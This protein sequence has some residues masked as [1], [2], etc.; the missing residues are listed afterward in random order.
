[1]ESVVSRESW[2]IPV[3]RLESATRGE[4]IIATTC[5]RWWSNRLIGVLVRGRMPVAYVYIVTER[6]DILQWQH[7]VSDGRVRGHTTGSNIGGVFSVHWVI[8]PGAAANVRSMH[9]QQYLGTPTV[10]V[11]G[12][13]CPVCDLGPEI[14][15]EREGAGYAKAKITTTT[16]TTTQQQKVVEYEHEKHSL[17]AIG[18][19]AIEK[20]LWKISHRLTVTS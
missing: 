1:M 16:K 18:K 5:W 10:V 3:I 9:L 15:Y 19:T 2:R 4:E 8:I 7:A 12:D 17:P 13:E 6:R 14:L 11:T 20:R